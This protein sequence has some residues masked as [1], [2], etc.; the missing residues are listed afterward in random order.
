[1]AFIAKNPFLRCE[2]MSVQAH[3]GNEPCREFRCLI[4]NRWKT[5]SMPAHVQ[6]IPQQFRPFHGQEALRMKLYPVQRPLLVS[7]PHDFA[8][9]RPSR[10]LE[11][12]VVECLTP[13]DQTV[14]A[15]C[16]ERIR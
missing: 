3:D 11:V 8:F 7:N 16:L 14:I 1:M 13:D 9:L 15:S 12:R 4:F 2:R 10:D 6:K 5:T